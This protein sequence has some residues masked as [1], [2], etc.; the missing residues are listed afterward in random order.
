MG[1]KKVG[2]PQ[3]PLWLQAQFQPSSKT[4]LT[5]IDMGVLLVEYSHLLC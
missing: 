2:G 3:I 4:I 5:Q 1:A